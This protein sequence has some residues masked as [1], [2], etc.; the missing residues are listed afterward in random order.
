MRYFLL[1]I[2]S[3]VSVLSSSENIYLHSNWKF[4]NIKNDSW[5]S[6]KV[7]G[8]IH[9]DL[10][11]NNVIPDPFYGDN[12]PKLKWIENEDWEYV[13]FFDCSNIM[14]LHQEIELNFEG[15]DTF[16][17]VYLNDSLILTTENMFREY[18]VSVK[19][20]L[21]EKNNKLKIVFSS[22]VNIGKSEMQKLNY[23]LPGDEKVFTR[24]AQ[25]QYGWDW[26]PRFVTCGIWKPVKLV[27]YNNAKFESINIIEQNLSNKL[28][29]LKI[30]FE[31]QTL[32]SG[33]YEIYLTHEPLDKNFLFVFTDWLLNLIGFSTSNKIEETN[34]IQGGNSVSINYQILNP[35]LWWANGMGGQFLY[36]FTIKLFYEGELIE[37][38][39]I[40][41]GLRK[42]ELVQEDDAK[43]KSFYFKLNGVPLFM[44]GANWIP[45]DNF[46]P[47]IS[48]QKYESLIQK[49][50]DANFNMLRVSG[51][52]IYEPNIFY[53]LCDKYG[54]L[55]WQDFMFSISL[56]PAD[57]NFIE[58]VKSEI[59]DN[60]KRLR[61]FSSI[62]L[63][64][65]NN[66]INEGW[67]NWGWQ[68]QFN[69][70]Y[71]D[72]VKIWEDYKI[73]FHST[74]KNVVDSLDKTRS[75][76]PSS[77]LFGWGRKESLTEGDMHYWGV[78]WGELPFDFYN[79][80]VGRFMS[81]FGFQGMPSF[82]SLQKY[83]PK[84]ELK[85]YSNAMK[86]HQKHPTGDE[87]IKKYMERDYIIPNDLENYSYVSQILQA[88]GIK[89]AIFAH[90][91]AKPYCMGTLF[92]QFNDCW[93][94]TS[95]SAIDYY[96]NNKALYYETKRSYT[97]LL[98]NVAEQNNYLHINIIS[99]L[100]RSTFANLELKLQDFNGNII[101]AKNILVD[102]KP[103]KSK[104]YFTLP[105]PKLDSTKKNKT[106]LVCK[107]SNGNY[108]SR[109]IF[110]FNKTK[111][112]KF[113]KP[114]IEI[115]QKNSTVIELK[116]NILA[117]NVYLY[118]EESEFE[119]SD[120]Y[121][122]MT[123]GEIK[124]IKNKFPINKANIKIKT[125]FDT[126]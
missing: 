33:K 26:G 18:F 59:I 10:F 89:T 83:I 43:G 96:N 29:N 114:K 68:K 38:K 62:A 118:S 22:S 9:T 77:P 7:P 80:K 12:E 53:E 51:A 21:K 100:L 72:S 99:E 4:R 104:I 61:N 52:G 13:T 49:A 17:K 65:G 120:N 55:V 85:L 6:A 60:V 14:L 76:W 92:W 44:K 23:K 25:Y 67:H 84:K 88:D 11:Q 5:Y 94:V 86:V 101:W 107:L 90:R 102:I 24:K 50:R 116:T 70:T 47:K 48:N 93:P 75:Y 19:K 121:F 64:C 3:F 35:K 58:N 15:L 105:V 113:E 69:Y 117:K 36:P 78:W 98:V 106:V 122:D 31:I 27:C 79:K 91:K 45:A 34:L 115:V 20:F 54:I 56:Y 109:F 87:F 66:E 28:A 124:I 103:N 111:Y 82:N 63:W 73:I 74:I 119:L 39:T 97:N 16:G 41:K 126:Y 8:T 123:P 57:N 1:F 46:V 42:I 40:K 30:D 81:E 37:T 2:F 95:W 125:L 110:Y 112:L 32:K 108:S 71:K